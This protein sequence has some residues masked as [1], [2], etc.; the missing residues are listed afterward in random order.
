MLDLLVA[1]AEA[2]A[3]QSRFGVSL[4]RTPQLAAQRAV[5]RPVRVAVRLAAVRRHA[6]MH[7]QLQRLRRGVR[8][9]RP[10]LRVVADFGGLVSGA[11]SS[12]LFI[13]RFLFR[14]VIDKM[15]KIRKI[16]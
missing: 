5:Q 7:A 9:F 13:A 16:R 1:V 4:L 6:T 14:L 10:A 3:V 11:S 2:R 15:L 8:R 12:D